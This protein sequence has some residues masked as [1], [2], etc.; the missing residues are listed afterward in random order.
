MSVRLR[1]E[2]GEITVD[3]ELEHLGRRGSWGLVILHERRIVARSVLASSKLGTLR[4]RV[5]VPDWIGSDA[6]VARASGP[7]SE[8]CRATATV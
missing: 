8:E 4:F 1:A 3:V 2:S 7:G 6:V 5:R